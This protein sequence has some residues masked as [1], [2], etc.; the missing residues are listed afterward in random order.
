M[1]VRRARRRPGENRARLLEA[2]LVEFGL[3]GYHGTS[4]AAIAARAE[5]PQPHVYTSFRTK[6][7]L[8]LACW[9]RVLAYIRAETPQPYSRGLLDRGGLPGV[10]DLLVN[11]SLPD[12]NDLLDSGRRLH[13]DTH[14]VNDDDGAVAVPRAEGRSHSDA[15]SP[16]MPG[17][18]A[19]ISAG[20]T[21]SSS[22]TDTFLRSR[23]PHADGASRVA[24][25]P[26]SVAVPYAAFVI[27]AVAAARDD[28]LRDVLQPSL[29]ALH[30]ELGKKR[31]QSLLGEGAAAL[32][33]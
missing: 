26:R 10:N 16:A 28:A 32:L 11:G 15:G 1:S 30:A 20:E 8:F 13:G 17:T 22:E 12:S 2:G 5:V 3:F 21:T 6:Q 19:S 29:C 4:T 14:L 33:T 23:D 18:A 24:A 7:E 9:E 31:W 27:H 25:A